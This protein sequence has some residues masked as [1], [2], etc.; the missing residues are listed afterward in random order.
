MKEG[1]KEMEAIEGVALIF[2]LLF[3]AFYL[4][5]IVFVIWFMITIVKNLKAQ[6]KLLENI[7]YKLDT[8]NNQKT[9]E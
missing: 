4:G 3:M 8:R 1:E 2:T 6:T 5:M 7:E 9:F